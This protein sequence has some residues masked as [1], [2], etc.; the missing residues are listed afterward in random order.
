MV[1]KIPQSEEKSL[2][3]REQMVLYL[4]A[5]GNV[6]YSDIIIDKGNTMTA[7]IL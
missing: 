4:Y 6:I 7:L 5:L 3:E 2:R 1:I